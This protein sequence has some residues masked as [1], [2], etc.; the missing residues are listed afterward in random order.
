MEN[1]VTI[2]ISKETLDFLKELNNRIETQSSRCTAKPY[3]L[4][5]KRIK[6]RVAHDD[7]Y[8]G[9]SKVVRVDHDNDYLQFDNFEEYKQHC[10]DAHFNEDFDLKKCEKDWEDLPSYT[11]EKYEEEDNVFLTDKGYEEH[12]Q[13]NEHNIKHG[14]VEY[15]SYLKHAFRNPEMEGIFKAIKEI[16]EANDTK[17]S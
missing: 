10:I 2:E 1:K 5:I 13:Q 15:Y 8:S 11:M 3:F 7:C 17:R 4:V 6:W 16:G 14:C 9:E 12:L